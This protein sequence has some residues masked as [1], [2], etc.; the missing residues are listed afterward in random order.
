MRCARLT[1]TTRTYCVPLCTVAPSTPVRSCANMSSGRWRRRARR[2]FTPLP[3]CA[4]PLQALACRLVFRCEPFHHLRG[5]QHLF[6]CTHTL[7]CAPDVL[8]GLRARAACAEIHFRRV[9]DREVVGVEATAHQ[10]VT[11]VVA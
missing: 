5:G 8:P 6:D 1:P 3:L 11:Q 9:G 10:A 7:A 2:A 4:Q